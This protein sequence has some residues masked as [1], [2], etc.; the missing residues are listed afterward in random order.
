[1]QS[2]RYTRFSLVVLVVAVALLLPGDGALAQSG[3]GYDLSCG[4]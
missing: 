1:M 4:R 2:K 3:E